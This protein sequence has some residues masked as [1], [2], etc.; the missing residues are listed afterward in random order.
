[1]YILSVQSGVIITLRYNKRGSGLWECANIL[2]LKVLFEN[3]FT[4]WKFTYAHL[5]IGSTDFVK[6]SCR[7]FYVCGL[8]K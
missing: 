4:L 2:V 1:M 3:S 7:I 5:L 6:K 8:I